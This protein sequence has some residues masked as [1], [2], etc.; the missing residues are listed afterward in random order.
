[1]LSYLWEESQNT[2]NTGIPL[3]FSTTFGGVIYYGKE[4]YSIR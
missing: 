3:L 2:F 4:D 1:M